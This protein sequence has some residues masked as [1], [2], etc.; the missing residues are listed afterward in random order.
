MPHEGIGPPPRTKRSVLWCLFVTTVFSGYSI[1]MCLLVCLFL[2][3][4]RTLQAGRVADETGGN[5]D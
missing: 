4:P 3:P 2:I 5:S 1:C